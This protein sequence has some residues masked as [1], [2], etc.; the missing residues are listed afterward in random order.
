MII[1]TIQGS[2]AAHSQSLCWEVTALASSLG[3]SRKQPHHQ[4][5]QQAFQR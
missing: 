3:I 2:E 4:R 1:L 5:P